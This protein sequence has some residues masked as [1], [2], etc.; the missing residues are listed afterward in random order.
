MVPARVVTVDVGAVEPVPDWSPETVWDNE[1]SVVDV[2]S[3][4]G[5][6]VVTGELGTVVDGT[7]G[8]G[9]GEDG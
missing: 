9:S 8:A 7:V 1:G 4:A 5:G 2:V 3:G 6:R